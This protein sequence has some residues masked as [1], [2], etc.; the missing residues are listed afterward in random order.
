MTSRFLLAAMVVVSCKTENKATTKTS[1]LGSLGNVD[2]AARLPDTI[3]PPPEGE[4]KTNEGTQ[5]ICKRPGQPGA[6]VK[7]K[8]NTF[9]VGRDLY[10]AKA[11]FELARVEDN[12]EVALSGQKPMVGGSNLTPGQPYRAIAQ[13]WFTCKQQGLKGGSY[14]GTGVVVFDTDGKIV[15]PP[16]E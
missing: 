13:V 4:H 15:P 8:W 6:D 16:A 11:Y 2:F 5:T 7:V 10:F 12:M 3:K 1:A 9:A 14:D